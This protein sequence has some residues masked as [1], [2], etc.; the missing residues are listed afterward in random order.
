VTP[1]ERV[2]EE[3]RWTPYSGGNAVKGEGV[4]CRYLLVRVLDELYGMP[5]RAL[6][7]RLHPHTATHDRRG[8]YISVG[9]LVRRYPCRA[10]RH[11]ALD[12]LEPGDVVVTR[13]H[14]EQTPRA[15]PAHCLIV[16]PRR[17]ELWHADSHVGVCTTSWG[18]WERDVIRGWRMLEKET[19]R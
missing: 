11:P 2:L 12:D 5:E 6:P 4:D 14:G 15:H 19:W 9:E 18:V 1:L 10:I 17:G 13:R 8:A 7:D 16:G 3:W